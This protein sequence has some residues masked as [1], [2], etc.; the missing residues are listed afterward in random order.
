M[1]TPID[2]LLKRFE[3]RGMKVVLGKNPDSGNIFVL[4]LDSD[5]IEMDGILI[6]KLEPSVVDDDQLRVLIILSQK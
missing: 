5:D 6:Q 3:G 1:T 4:P 2:E